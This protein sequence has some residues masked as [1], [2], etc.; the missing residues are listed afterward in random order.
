MSFKKSATFRK[1]IIGFLSAIVVGTVIS[2]L[3]V[4][5]LKIKPKEFFMFIILFVRNIMLYTIPV[6]IILALSIIILVMLLIFRNKRP[7]P[8]EW[9]Q[10]TKREYKG[11]FFEWSYVDKEPWNFYE[12]CP[13]CGCRIAEKYCPCCEYKIQRLDSLSHEYHLYIEDLKNVIRHNIETGAYKQY[14][15]KPH[16]KAA[17]S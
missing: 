15:N 4:L 9:L 7:R 14:L 13:K 3:S 5:I 12:L 8:P 2:V 16:Q 1:A 17:G 11:R 6:W 10:Y